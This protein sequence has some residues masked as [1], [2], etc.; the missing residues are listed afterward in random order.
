[1]FLYFIQILFP[2]VYI[3]ILLGLNQPNAFPA[4]LL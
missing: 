3:T 1:M 4:H 2:K